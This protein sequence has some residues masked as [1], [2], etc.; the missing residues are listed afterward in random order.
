MIVAHIDWLTIVGRRKPEPD[1]WSVNSAYLTATEWLEARSATFREAFG[2]PSEWQIVRPRAPYSFARRS[3]DCTRTLYVHPLAAHFTLEVS[4]AHCAKL[5]ALMPQVLADYSD[6]LSR[7]DLAVDIETRT[8]PLEFDALTSPTRINTRSRM[9]SS[10]GETVYVGSRS[11]ER[12]V[13]IYRY[14]APHPRSHLLRVEFQLKGDF[15]R[16]LGQDAGAGAS[17]VGI[18]AELGNHFGF[19]H[20]DWKPDAI[21]SPLR[22][23]SHAQTGNTIHWLTTTVAPLLRRLER[24]QRLDVE[25]W[26]DEYV[27]KHP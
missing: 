9:A 24:E 18:A 13:R 11:S 20:P 10:T 16:A 14:T 4:G 23:K 2:V 26:L 1:D 8:T 12:F 15:A 25:A 22:V 6:S 17:L 21:P 5:S 3:G 27:R 19:H 7:V